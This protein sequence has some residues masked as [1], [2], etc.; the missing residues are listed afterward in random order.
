MA[1]EEKFGGSD[2]DFNTGLLYMEALPTVFIATTIGTHVS[3]GSLPIVYYGNEYQKKNIYL[4]LQP[5]I[6]PAYAL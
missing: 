3:I 6:K 5:E 4:E 1:I 2:L